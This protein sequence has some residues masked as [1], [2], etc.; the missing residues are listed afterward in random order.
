[1]K[2]T[3]IDQLFNVDFC[4]LLR[5]H[6]VYVLGCRKEAQGALCSK[7]GFT[8]TFPGNQDVGVK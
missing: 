7:W 2:A 6:E 1:M 8:R 3:K 4:G 5:K